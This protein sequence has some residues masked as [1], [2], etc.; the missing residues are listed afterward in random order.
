MDFDT[1]KKDRSFN[2]SEKSSTDFNYKKQESKSTKKPIE[3]LD[4]DY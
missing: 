3:D 2:S 1:K 4:Y